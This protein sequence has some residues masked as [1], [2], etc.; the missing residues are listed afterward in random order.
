MF[1]SQSY[2]VPASPSPWSS[3]LRV[4]SPKLSSSQ[5][6]TEVNIQ[7]FQLFP[8]SSCFS[9][10]ILWVPDGLV[11]I[12]SKS[13]RYEWSMS[14]ITSTCSTL[15]ESGTLVT[16]LI[17]GAELSGIC[18]SGTSIKPDWKLISGSTLTQFSANATAALASITPNPYL[19]LTS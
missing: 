12:I 5:W 13:P 11:K 9:D 19:W 6:W 4:Q 3:R 7:L 14:T 18:L 16:S 8:L 15:I 17:P 1:S 2:R 10:N